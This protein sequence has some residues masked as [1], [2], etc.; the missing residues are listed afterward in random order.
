M[1]ERSLVIARG[2][3]LL[4]PWSAADIETWHRRCTE[5]RDSVAAAK[6]TGGAFVLGETPERT[7]LLP[8]VCARGDSFTLEAAIAGLFVAWAAQRRAEGLPVD[9]PAV[10]TLAE[11]AW[12][13]IGGSRI[14]GSPPPLEGR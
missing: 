3:G 11:N 2:S 8:I 1:R 10:A 13:M 12:E 5:F 14:E 6:M 9:L 7:G 4:K